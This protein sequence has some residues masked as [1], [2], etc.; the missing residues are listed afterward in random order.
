MFNGG[1]DGGGVD[2]KRKCGPDS[3]EKRLFHLRAKV[4]RSDTTLN[5]DSLFI[6]PSAPSALS[7]LVEYSCPR[8][9]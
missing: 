9:A 6:P 3:E 2:P 5:I 1:G 8:F 4:W 7:C